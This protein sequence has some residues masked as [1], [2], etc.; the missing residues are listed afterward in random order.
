LEATFVLR[1]QDI[2]ARLKVTFDY[3]TTALLLSLCGR[4]CSCRAAQR[5]PALGG[6]RLSA[7]KLLCLNVPFL[8]AL[9]KHAWEQLPHLRHVLLMAGTPLPLPL[10]H[11]P[12]AGVASSDVGSSGSS[13]GVAGSACGMSGQAAAGQAV[14]QGTFTLQEL[15]QQWQQQLHFEQHS[16][17]GELDCHYQQQQQQQQPPWQQQG[18]QLWEAEQEEQWFAQQVAQQNGLCSSNANGTQGVDSR[19]VH[20]GR[21][22]AAAAEQGLVLSRAAVDALHDMVLSC[23][24]RTC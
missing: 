4:A 3:G 8:M 5:V 1:M 21:G 6:S 2:I 10:Q 7:P 17:A 12:Q 11:R 20:T 14:V 16:P 13:S 22:G 19:G 18:Q 15:E 23:M 9:R 24:D